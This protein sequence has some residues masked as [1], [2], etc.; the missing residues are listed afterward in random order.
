MAR[1]PNYGPPG[2]RKPAKRSVGKRGTIFFVIIL[3]ELEKI[4]SVSADDFERSLGLFFAHEN[5]GYSNKIKFCLSW[6][7]SV[8]QMTLLFGSDFALG[9]IFS[10]TLFALAASA[11]LTSVRTTQSEWYATEQNADM[12]VRTLNGIDGGFVDP[13]VAGWENHTLTGQVY[14]ISYPLKESQI[15]NC[16]A[17]ERD[18]AWTAQGKDSVC[19]PNTT[20]EIRVYIPASYKN[21]AEAA[22]LFAPDDDAAPERG[23]VGCVHGRPVAGPPGFYMNAVMLDRLIEAGRLPQNIIHITNNN[24]AVRDVETNTMSGR[25]AEFLQLEVL[26]RVQKHPPIK[27]RYNQLLFTSNP[28]GRAI[29]GCSAGGD[30]AVIATY[31]RPGIIGVAIAYS[32]TLTWTNTMLE[33]NNTHPIGA[34]DLWAQQ[35]LW[36]TTP[37][38]DIRLF[39][40]CGQHDMG[41]TTAPYT[42]WAGHDSLQGQG[43][44]AGVAAPL[45]DPPYEGSAFI[46]GP[47][48]QFHQNS[49]G[50]NFGFPGKG[51]GCNAYM[52]WAEANNRT[53]QDMHTSG[54]EHHYVWVQNGCH[55]DPRLYNQVLPDSLTWA[56]APY[57]KTITNPKL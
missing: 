33:S 57:T 52:D 37:K 19:T 56:F 18:G 55:C 5:T 39:H 44:V 54:Y 36:A 51:A 26:P 30:Q 27:Q 47:G 2:A 29:L 13:L 12:V 16:S 20:R 28:K 1:G 8:R 40:T 34:A 49:A 15:Y 10:A 35:R 50:R 22:V 25:F 48:A 4:R 53:A 23:C 31:F 17:P 14:T 45:C 9:C 21:G 46:P 3:S 42:T 7:R 38:R 24:A 6:K 41:T 32:A 11:P 43:C